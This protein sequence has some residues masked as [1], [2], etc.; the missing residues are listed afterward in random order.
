[1]KRRKLLFVTCGGNLD[2]ENDSVFHGLCTL[3][4]TEV[5]IL[6][7]NSFDYMFKGLRTEEQLRSLYGK[8]FTLANRIPV[9]KK[10][11]HSREEA[12]NN[13]RSHY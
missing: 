11:V 3:P 6:N 7:E 10:C 5:A 9:D 8:G 2:Y 4:E 12:L 1:M 13:L